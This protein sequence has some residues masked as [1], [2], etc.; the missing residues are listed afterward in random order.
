MIPSTSTQ[1]SN[2]SPTANLAHGR[3][4]GSSNRPTTLVRVLFSSESLQQR[5]V[6]MPRV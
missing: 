2:S 4:L 5:R 3:V 6:L 1:I